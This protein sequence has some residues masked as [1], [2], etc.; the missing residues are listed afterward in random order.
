MPGNPRHYPL[1]FEQ[2]SIWLAENLHQEPARYLESWTYR[3]TG[4]VDVSALEA[5][6]TDVV[7]R[8]EVLR[9]AIYV[10]NGELMQTVGHVPNPALAIIDCAPGDLESELR[11]IIKTP[12]DLTTSPMRGYLIR[13]AADDAVL[14]VQLHHIVVDDWAL[15]VLD[16][17][18][19]ECYRARIERRSPHLVPLPLQLGPYARSQ[20]AAGIDPEVLRY[21]RTALRDLPSP[22]T[23]PADRPRPAEPSWQ[24]AELA[25]EI[26][27]GLAGRVRAVSRTLRTTP[28]TIFACAL[29]SLLA[30]TA[31]T[32]DV[33]IGAPVSR[34]GA[35]DLD[36]MIACITDVLPLR[37]AVRPDD[38]FADLAG[39]AKAAVSGAVA[40]AAISHAEL[41]R[42]V[43]TRRQRAALPLCRTVLVVDNAG[44][45]TLDLPGVAAERLHV[46][47]GIA[48][49]DL[50]LTLVADK[51]RYLGFLEYATDLLEA[52]S[53]E[54]VVSRLCQLLEMATDQPGRTMRDLAAAAVR[55]RDDDE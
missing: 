15:H 30:A 1:T 17:D 9:S 7:L 33:I 37:I 23:M 48:K 44:Q 24:G 50:C 21:W 31:D 53:A 3:L 18:F 22:S 27:A 11:R 45:G 10:T 29:A 40:H 34:R 52:R 47:T 35:A 16:H 32:E 42:R 51:G 12:I 14:A 8:H 41:S 28:F 38:S 55:D 5:A 25:F 13:L 36:Q 49:F 46:H 6:L 2:E 39:S 26:D 54:R 20:R 4:S 19:A 43:L